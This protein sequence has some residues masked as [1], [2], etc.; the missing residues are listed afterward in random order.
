M[1]LDSNMIPTMKWHCATFWLGGKLDKYQEIIPSCSFNLEPSSY[2]TLSNDIFI[3]CTTNAFWLF[4]QLPT[5]SHSPNLQGWILTIRFFSVISRTL[6]LGG[7]S[8]PPCRYTVSVFYSPSRLGYKL[9][10]AISRTLVGEGLSPRQRCIRCTLRPQPTGLYFLRVF[11]HLVIYQVFLS[12]I[13]G[14]WTIVFIFI[15]ISTTFRPMSSGLLQLFVELRNLH[16][17]SN[18]V[19]Y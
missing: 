2:C 8:L 1:S 3:Y 12:M 15:V 5:T 13:K 14:F 6:V 9:F 19:L 17:T 18:Y 4:H 7:G 10:S 16:K 11:L